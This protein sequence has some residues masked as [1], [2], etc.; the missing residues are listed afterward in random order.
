MTREQSR[1]ECEALV[2]TLDLPDPFDLA[3]LCSRLGKQRGK[4]IVLMPHS[5]VFGN[6]CGLWM[7]TAKAD[8]VFYEQDT[9]KLHQQHIVFH[10]IGHILRRH[11]PRY[12]S[13]DVARVAAPGVKPGDVQQVLGRDSYTDDLEFEAE[14]TATLILRRVDRCSV[15]ETA[16]AMDP[17][18]GEVIARIAYSLSR[19]VR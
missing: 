10:E 8:Y 7:G 14:L 6:V 3:E 9:S 12:V 15:R 1:R 18:A 13:A 4:P 16:R 5:M 11:P 2:A 17:A 19:G